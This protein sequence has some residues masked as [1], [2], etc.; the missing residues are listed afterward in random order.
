MHNATSDFAN[1]FLKLHTAHCTYYLGVLYLESNRFPK[2]DKVYSTCIHNT[3]LID[4][5]LPL[6]LHVLQ[7]VNILHCA[8]GLSERAC[9]FSDMLLV[10]Q[11]FK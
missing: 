8:T 4:G 2:T 5:I 9:V 6:F 10:L 1:R 3:A 7:V 11:E